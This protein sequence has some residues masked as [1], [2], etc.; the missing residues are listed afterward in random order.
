MIFL[1]CLLNLLVYLPPCA[2]VGEGSSNVGS[3]GGILVSLRAFASTVKA[4]SGVGRLGVNLCVECSVVLLD[5]DIEKR[6]CVVYAFLDGEFEARC[7]LKM[8]FEL[9]GF[10]IVF[11]L[12]EDVVYISAVY[13]RLLFICKHLFFNAAHKEI[14]QQYS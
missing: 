3:Y 4:M 11:R 5:E 2:A 14:S 1:V 7:F 10:R 12:D 9:L 6:Q 8:L 13:S